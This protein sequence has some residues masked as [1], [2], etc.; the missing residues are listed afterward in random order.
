M[1][2]DSQL[3]CFFSSG[4]HDTVLAESSV[5]NMETKPNVLKVQACAHKHEARVHSGTE[6]VTQLEFH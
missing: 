5:H 4:Q 1:L 6:A 2:Q 3:E